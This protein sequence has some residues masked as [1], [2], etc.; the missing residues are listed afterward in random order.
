MVKHFEEL[1]SFDKME[2][3]FSYDFIKE[4]F[5]KCVAPE[6]VLDNLTVVSG[7]QYSDGNEDIPLEYFQINSSNVSILFFLNTDVRLQQLVGERIPYIRQRKLIAVA[8]NQLQPDRLNCEIRSFSKISWRVAM[9]KDG[10]SLRNLFL[11]A[12]EELLDDFQ[13]EE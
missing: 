7:K 10:M 13:N 9:L 8:Q 11:I 4:S 1:S 6:A 5:I 2:R 12:M 3:L